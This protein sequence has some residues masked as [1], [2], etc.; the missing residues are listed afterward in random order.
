MIGNEKFNFFQDGKVGTRF[1]ILPETYK[2]QYVCVCIYMYIHR[3]WFN[4]GNQI[5]KESNFKRWEH[6]MGV[7]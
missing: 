4:I 5:T 6:I 3:Q 1:T 7:S 2:K